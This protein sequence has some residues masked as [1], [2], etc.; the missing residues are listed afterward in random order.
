VKEFFCIPFATINN[1]M[2]DQFPSFCVSLFKT[3]DLQYT[4]YFK[5]VETSTNL[6]K[7][8]VCPSYKEVLCNDNR[9][10]IKQV[11]ENMYSTI[12]HDGTFEQYA[13]LYFID[14]QRIYYFFFDSSF[15]TERV[16]YYF[17][18]KLFYEQEYSNNFF[19]PN[20]LSLINSVT[21]KDLSKK[22]LQSWQTRGPHCC[23]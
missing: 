6:K 1:E 15:H 17:D 11:L 21:F 9:F 5:Q 18:L 14:K 23:W 12:E 22:M 3:N 16:N 13:E 4:S 19:G 7:S 10:D 8:G 20:L 2:N